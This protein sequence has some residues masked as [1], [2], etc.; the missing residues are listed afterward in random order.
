MLDFAIASRLMQRFSLTIDIQCS[1][2]IP[3]VSL[4]AGGTVWEITLH[5]L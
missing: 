5:L 1:R 2:F 4:R 3:S